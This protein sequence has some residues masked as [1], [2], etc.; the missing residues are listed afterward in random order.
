[1]T[2]KRWAF[3]ILG[4]VAVIAG[5]LLW[6]NLR[7][8]PVPANY[9]SSESGVSYYPACRNETLTHGG[10]TWYPIS[11]DDWPTPSAGAAAASGGRGVA[12]SVP[13]V[14]APGPGDDVGTLY[15][16]RDGIAYWVSD[17]GTLWTWL[18]LVPQ[19]YNW[20]C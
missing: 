11:R 3:T 15:L 17:S 13:M 18:T 8:G 16:Y 6:V 12:A 7:V 2:K 9:E 20:V 4:A 5:A 19:A 1:M 14:A 10:L